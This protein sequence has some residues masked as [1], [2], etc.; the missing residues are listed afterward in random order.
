MNELYMNKAMLNP[1]KNNGQTMGKYTLF[2]TP[3]EI[4]LYRN[5]NDPWRYPNTDWYAATF[6]NWSPQR[7]HKC[8]TGRRFGQISVFRKLRS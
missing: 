7:V 2:R 6:K 4:E 5:G 3:E 8:I 1:A